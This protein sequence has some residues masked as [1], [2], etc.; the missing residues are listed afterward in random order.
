LRK[1][2]IAAY[3]E[4]LAVQEKGTIDLS[5]LEISEMIAKAFMFWENRKLKNTA[6]CIMPNHVHW[7]FRLK[8]KDENSKPVY[9]QDIMHSVKR[10][11]ANVINKLTGKSGALWQKESFDTTIRD[12]EHE[13]NAVKYTLNNPVKAGFV[14]D[15]QVWQGSWCCEEYKGDV[16]G[17]A[18][19]GSN[20]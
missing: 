16:L 3:D 7:I 6:F 12:M 19:N 15:W 8:E 2:Y 10:Q 13:Y 1:K 9:L 18:V 17:P 11:T 4:L 14:K 5:N 20:G